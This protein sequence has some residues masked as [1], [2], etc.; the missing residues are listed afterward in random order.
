MP[1]APMAER[2]SYGPTRVPGGRDDIPYFGYPAHSHSSAC[3]QRLLLHRRGRCGRRCAR[4]RTGSDSPWRPAPWPCARSRATQSCMSS[5]ITFGLS[6]SR[7]PTSIQMRIGFAGLFG[8]SV[9]WIFPGAARRLRVPRPLLIHARARIRSTR[10]YRSLRYH[11]MMNAATPPEL[12]P[13]VARPSGSFVSFTLHCFSTS[14]S[15]SVSTNS[16]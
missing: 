5:R 1:P 7:S 15:T 13:I 11:A 8:M 14:G 12:P 2:T 3:G 9:R 6:R 10:W 16:A 4:R